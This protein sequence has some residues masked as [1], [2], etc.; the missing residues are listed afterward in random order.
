MAI[1]KLSFVH[2]FLLVFHN[3]HSFSQNIHIRFKFFLKVN[4]HEEFFVVQLP[5]AG[6][7]VWDVAAVELCEFSD[8][9]SRQK[10]ERTKEA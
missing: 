7:D 5:G 1:N 10:V 6:H 9:V 8:I 3:S 2:L 4:I